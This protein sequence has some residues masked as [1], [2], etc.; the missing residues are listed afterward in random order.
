M[1]KIPHYITELENIYSEFDNSWCQKNSL[2]LYLARKNKLAIGGSI[3]IAISR[4]KAHKMPGD[5]DFFTSSY[6][7]AWTFVS[8]LLDYLSR[9]SGT[10][11]DIKFQ[12]ETKF[13]LKGVKNYFRITIPFWLPICVM[14]LEEPVRKFYWETIAVQYFDDIVVAAK[15][16]TEIDKKVERLSF[17]INFDDID[18]DEERHA[19]VSFQKEQIYI[20]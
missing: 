14:V 8:M 5:F 7:D 2:V 20:T 9:K 11:G 17:T 15:T 13:T 19:P 18:L 4:K 6:K 10:Y 12:N 1:K 16:T 3:G